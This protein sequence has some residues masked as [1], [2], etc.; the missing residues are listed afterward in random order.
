MKH[1]YRMIGNQLLIVPI[2]RILLH[3]FMTLIQNIMKNVFPQKKSV[4]VIK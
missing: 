4:L 3:C 1:C 2:V